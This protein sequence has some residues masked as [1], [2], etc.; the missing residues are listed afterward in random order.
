MRYTV[1]WHRSA[2]NQLATLWTSSASRGSF[3]TA[4]ELVD[5]LLGD[6][7]GS[8]GEAFYGDRLL[9]AEPLMVTFK[10]EENDRIVVILDVYSK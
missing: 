7:P 8:E 2:L 4:V 6:D 3:A 5:Q 9:V 10:I 1:T